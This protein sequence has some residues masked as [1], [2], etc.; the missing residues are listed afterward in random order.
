MVFHLA[1]E[2]RNSKCDMQCTDEHCFASTSLTNKV[3]V[4]IVI[5]TVV[6]HLATKSEHT[7]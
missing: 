4:S 5:Q 1:E 2:V 7:S 3:V 6:S